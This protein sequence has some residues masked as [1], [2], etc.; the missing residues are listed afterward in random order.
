MPGFLRITGKRKVIE[1]R[2]N[3]WRSLFPFGY[4]VPWASKL[5]SHVPGIRREQGK[6]QGASEEDVKKKGMAASR[7]LIM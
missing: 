4:R 1:I 6:P 3:C 5:L 7:K 2:N